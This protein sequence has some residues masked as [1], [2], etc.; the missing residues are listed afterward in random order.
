MPA[1]G[2]DKP[3]IQTSVPSKGSQRHCGL[4]HE[5]RNVR[6]GGGGDC[7]KL[8]SFGGRGARV[9][10]QIKEVS[11]AHVKTVTKPAKASP[12]ENPQGDHTFYPADPLNPPCYQKGG[13]LY[14][15]IHGAFPG[16]SEYRGD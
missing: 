11:I 4:K 9:S 10:I 2:G 15:T 8:G 7:S 1:C 5:N 3:T 16:P 14:P 12:D 13:Q 6:G